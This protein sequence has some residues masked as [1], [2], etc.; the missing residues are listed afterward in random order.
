M[1]SIC[2]FICFLSIVAATAYSINSGNSDMLV[3]LIIG[4]LV[5]GISSP[6]ILFWQD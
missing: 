2:A 4:G 1:R 5:F 6:I 3:G